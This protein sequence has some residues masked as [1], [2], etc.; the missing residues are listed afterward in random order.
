MVDSRRT[1]DDPEEL[2]RIIAE[3]SG[4]L[5]QAKAGLVAKSLEVE[6]LKLQ[7][8]RLRR[9]QFGR[10]SERIGREIEQ[11]ELRLE[12]LE[13]SGSSEAEVVEAELG[14]GVEPA[15]AK[16]RAGRRPL[17][18]HL[19]RPGGHARGCLQLPVLRRR[20]A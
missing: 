1:T 18:D 14:S 2:R 16:P 5:A 13:A 9:M 8:A 6:K 7:I 10:S 11:L 17:P 15:T 4:E 3:L 20:A 12:E 19:P